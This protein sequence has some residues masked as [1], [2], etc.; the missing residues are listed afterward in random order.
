MIT[1]TDKKIIVAR[2]LRGLERQ[3]FTN[4]YNRGNFYDYVV[5][6]KPCKTREEIAEDI[7]KLLLSGVV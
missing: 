6:E 3:T 7:E 1:K 5:G 4:W 2:I